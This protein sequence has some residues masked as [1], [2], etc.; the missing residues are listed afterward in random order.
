M[1]PQSFR[2]LGLSP[3]QALDNSIYLSGKACFRLPKPGVWKREIV[4]HI[5]T[6]CLQAYAAD[7]LE[8]T[9]PDPSYVCH[10]KCSVVT[11]GQLIGVGSVFRE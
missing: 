11:L 1:R 8:L 5:A 4:K 7:F 10:I 3:A 2:G 6:S 9:S